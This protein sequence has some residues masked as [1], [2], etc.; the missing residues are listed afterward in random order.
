MAVDLAT[1]GALTGPSS[2]QA[3]PKAKKANVSGREVLADQLV[4]WGIAT[5]TFFLVFFGDPSENRWRRHPFFSLVDVFAVLMIGFGLVEAAKA[6]R[7][8]RRLPSTPIAKALV[9]LLG[10]LVLSFAVHPSAMGLATLMHFG[11]V[12]VIARQIEQRPQLVR[13]VILTVMSIATFEAIVAAGQFIGKRALGLQ[14]LGEVLDPFITFGDGPSTALVPSGT[15]FHPYPLTGFC[16]LAVALAAVAVRAS[17]VKP[18]FAIFTACMC[19]VM[20]GLS[21]SI[22]A[23]LTAAL[24]G[25][26]LLTASV[27]A[28]KKHKAQR[29][30][31]AV[32]LA[33]ALGISVAAP[34]AKAAWQWKGDRTSQGV[35]AAGNGRVALLR[36]AGEM[37]KRW[38]ITGV[39]PGRYM[40]ERDANP[41][42][43]AVAKEPQPVHNLFA[44]VVVESGVFGAVALLYLLSQTFRAM[45]R[46]WMVVL[47]VGASLSGN[48]MLDHYLW[49]FTA[50]SVQLGVAFGVIGALCARSVGGG[51]FPLGSDTSIEPGTTSAEINAKNLEPSAS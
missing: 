20:V 36:Q 23:A 45:R 42:I 40:A 19:G 43:A 27:V 29:P 14:I 37:I 21:A 51:A 13:P 6:L 17:M 18:A 3:T 16:L 2:V 38:P 44:L 26:A 9:V 31:A 10:A 30:V 35:E 22:A 48:L 41:E 15:M 49:L 8:G 34:A 46:N 24:L 4:I 33:F 28:M 50:G 25:V 39:G 12:V 1:P 47:I 32:L 7:A 11:V 5:S